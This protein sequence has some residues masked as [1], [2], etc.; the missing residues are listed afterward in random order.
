MN[1]SFVIPVYNEAKNIDFL[2]R[3]LKKISSREFIVEVLIVDG[4]SEDNTR[5]IVGKLSDELES[6]NYKLVFL[7]NP[8]KLQAEALNIGLSK[9]RFDFCVRI[10]AHI[11]L[12]SIK[13]IRS[14]LK[15]SYKL[16]LK[17]KVCS[18]GYKQRF[19]ISSNLIQNSLYIL[20]MS[21]FLSGF[22]GY[23][24]SLINKF[25]YSA[26]WLFSLIKSNALL[27]GGF[28]LEETPNEDMGFNE[29]LIKTTNLPLF[30]DI[31]LPIYY[32][33]RDNFNKLFNQYYRYG[34][35]RSMRRLKDKTKISSIFA[36]IRPLTFLVS[37]IFLSL[38]IFYSRFLI[39][40]YAVLVLF[41]FIQFKFDEL[42][43]L[44][45]FPLLTIEKI[46]L[47]LAFFVTPITLF[48]VL[49]ASFIGSTFCFFKIQK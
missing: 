48:I 47:L 45:K 17:N 28:I 35:S 4:G 9:A 37:L 10:D 32:Y 49:L 22:R 25:S 38:L 16:L 26:V 40:F 8:L 15:S 18:I 34:F 44:R 39:F 2:V 1:I 27:S 24:L 21:P 42:N 36:I 23:R 33:P 29:R 3:K 7:E 6:D 19:S 30:L 43:Y 12:G 31:N 11:N 5:L 20:S 14:S 13:L 41:C 46:S